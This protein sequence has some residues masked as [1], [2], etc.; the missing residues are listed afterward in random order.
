MKISTIPIVYIKAAL[1][2][3]KQQGC[4]CNELLSQARVPQEQLESVLGRVSI[5]TYVEFSKILAV[6]LNDESCG[7]LYPPVQLGSFSML[8]HS[9]INCR[10]LG[11]FLHRSVK[12]FALIG[13][14][15]EL[16]LSIKDDYAYYSINITKPSSAE[17][18]HAVMILMAIAHRLSSWAINKRITLKEVNIGHCV[19]SAKKDYHY[20]FDAPVNF[21]MA[22]NEL[23]FHANFLTSPVMQDQQSLSKFLEDPIITLLSSMENDNSLTS[24]IRELVKDNVSANFPSFEDVAD[25]LHLTTST[26]RRRLAVEGINYRQ[27]KD[28]LR[29]DSAIYQLEQGITIEQVAQN[30]G[31]A[32]PSSFFRS[33]KRWTGTTPKTYIKNPESTPTEDT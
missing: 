24:K 27:I 29:R 20:L 19:D 6:K 25:Q 23:V 12:F 2:R 16:K 5:A 32:E 22:K 33:F 13:N 26:L 14:N 10:D 4:D 30:I 18:K 9:C 11:H 1:A 28:D 7:L 17:S 3:A 8:C 31:F 15:L 21:N